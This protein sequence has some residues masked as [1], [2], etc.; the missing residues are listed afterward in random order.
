M[1]D[2]VYTKT[3]NIRNLKGY[4]ASTLRETSILNSLNHPNVIRPIE[5]KEEG[6]RIMIKMK[7][8][9]PLD[10]K[11]IKCV[12]IFM[13]KLIDALLYIH[14][15]SILYCDIKDDNILLDGD[16]PLFIDFGNS[17]IGK[18]STLKSELT[19]DQYAAPDTLLSPMSDVWSLGIV[20]LMIKANITWKQLFSDDKHFERVI[21]YRDNTNDEMIIGMLQM[22]S[23]K[24]WSLE[25]CYKYL[26]KK[27]PPLYPTMKIK[28]LSNCHQ[29]V[30]IYIE[31]LLYTDEVI[32]AD[33]FILKNV[34]QLYKDM[35]YNFIVY[36][37]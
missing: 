17:V 3:C 18:T 33:D 28:K 27:D 19:T 35:N 5:M 29:S 34:K 4:N 15:R 22:D 16:N 11:S 25:K 31:T 14:S 6:N 23:I 36:N 32:S 26:M 24:R 8:Y 13:A 37:S 9:K 7:R 20:F 21:R 30:I 2:D 10:M 1:S 12:K